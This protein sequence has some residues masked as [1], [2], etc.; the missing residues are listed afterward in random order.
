MERESRRLAYLLR[1]RPDVGRLTLERGGWAKIE[2]VLAAMSIDRDTLIAIVSAP[3]KRRFEL[4]HDRVR[5][6]HG[7]SV[8]VELDHEPADPPERLFHGTVAR[9]LPSIRERGLIARRRAYVH[10]SSTIEEAREVGARRGAPVVI[11][12]RAA[13]LASDGTIFLRVPGSTVWLVDHV[14]PEHLVVP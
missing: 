6:L 2:L 5:A 1:H 3:G 4:D 10:L 7:H 13:A 8:D 14:P 11:E 9:Y 12:V